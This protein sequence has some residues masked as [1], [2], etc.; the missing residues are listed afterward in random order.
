[1]DHYKTWC[2]ILSVTVLFM[3]G[4]AYRFYDN[5]KQDLTCRNV[6]AKYQYLLQHGQ[7]LTA[8]ELSDPGPE[9]IGDME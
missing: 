5:G 1:M 4:A 6:D 8:E 3:T 2:Y 9:A 7:D